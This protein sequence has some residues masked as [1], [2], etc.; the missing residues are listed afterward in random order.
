MTHLRSL[1]AIASALCGIGCGLLIT[2]AC[3]SECAC[4]PPRPIVTGEFAV[5]SVEFS[6]GAPASLRDLDVESL[7]VTGAGI[8]VHYSRLNEVGTAT[9]AIGNRY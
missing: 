9:F 6:D 4:P 7:S 3:S 2:S 1:I 8:T 5:T